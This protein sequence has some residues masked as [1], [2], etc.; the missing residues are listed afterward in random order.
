MNKYKNSIHLKIAAILCFVVA[1]FFVR[2]SYAE[3]PSCSVASE[4]CCI[5]KGSS[6]ILDIN[7]E[8]KEICFF[9]IGT[10]KICIEFGE[11]YDCDENGPLVSVDG[12]C[13]PSES[14][15]ISFFKVDCEN[16]K[17][18]STYPIEYC[19]EYECASASE[20]P[21]CEEHSDCDGD[22]VCIAGICKPRPKDIFLGFIKIEQISIIN[23]NIKYTISKQDENEPQNMPNEAK[24]GY[25]CRLLDL[26]FNKGAC[27]Y[28]P[29]NFCSL[30]DGRFRDVVYFSDV[31]KTSKKYT[32]ECNKRGGYLC[33]LLPYPLNL[34]CAENLCD[35]FF[36]KELSF[37]ICDTNSGVSCSQKVKKSGSKYGTLNV[38]LADYENPKGGYYSYE[39]IEI[40]KVWRPGSADKKTCRDEEA[41][42]LRTVNQLKPCGDGGVCVDGECKE[43]ICIPDDTLHENEECDPKINEFWVGG[44]RKSGEDVTCIDFGLMPKSENDRPTCSEYCMIDLSN[45]ITYEEY[46]RDSCGNH[47][48]DTCG[49]PEKCDWYRSQE[50]EYFHP[51]GEVRFRTIM[52]AEDHTTYCGEREGLIGD[53]MMLDCREDCRHI[54]YELCMKDWSEEYPEV[55]NESDCSDGFNNNYWYV[56]SNIDE[57]IADDG[58]FDINKV[59]Y[60]ISLCLNETH[61]TDCQDISCHMR[62]GN[63]GICN[64]MEELYCNDGFD[65]NGNGLVDIEDPSCSPELRYNPSQ[66]NT[67]LCNVHYNCYLDRDSRAGRTKELCYEHGEMVWDKEG[68]FICTE[69]N[70]WTSPLKAMA[71]LFYSVSD[72]NEFSIYC[73]D[74]GDREEGYVVA[75]NSKTPSG[76]EAGELLRMIGPN[77]GKFCA[78][79]SG[80]DWGFSAKI[81]DLNEKNL[82][83]SENKVQ[84]VAAL[85]SAN[86]A[87]CNSVASDGE[88]SSLERCM[89]ENVFLNS[90]Y[91]LIF[92]TNINLNGTHALSGIDDIRNAVGRDGLFGFFTNE[93]PHQEHGAK[94]QAFVW[95]K[96]QDNDNQK[97]EIIGT[98]EEFDGTVYAVILYNNIKD[99]EQICSHSLKYLRISSRTSGTCLQIADDT[100]LVTW[101]F[102]MDSTEL[103]ASKKKFNELVRNIKIN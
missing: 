65:N 96:N 61:C 44:E 39:C 90:R 14:C 33:I 88:S 38:N 74:Y 4:S 53:A 86:K 5:S 10:T 83:S 85:F 59:R 56:I 31:S 57:S 67:G 18:C 97:K 66:S 9:G 62:D 89:D 101:S 6:C 47:Q 55:R 98:I 58:Y 103:Q 21:E 100:Y 8:K 91:G 95:K 24:T 17:I 22:Q 94:T 82:L 20:E 7:C 54:S 40:E 43:H 34:A 29:Y 25:Y 45:C 19:V 15:K 72:K 84:D 42:G 99:F 30:F 1:G 63:G 35:G 60:N 77:F 64:F 87:A 70:F 11:E 12:R 23:N 75:Y 36:T 41:I 2:V 81:K 3:L 48:I 28:H 68:E 26:T 92:R 79:T 69:E 27:S 32:V 71:G 76:I 78:F 80:E 93:I 13:Y 102:E 46:V 50:S 37:M 51:Y 16:E 49:I 73:N 52:L